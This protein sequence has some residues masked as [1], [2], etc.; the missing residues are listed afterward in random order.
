MTEVT[1]IR[2]ATARAI[3]AK[4]IPEIID[5]NPFL[6]LLKYLRAMNRLTLFTRILSY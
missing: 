6:L 3:P 5:T 2:T 4:A 1:T